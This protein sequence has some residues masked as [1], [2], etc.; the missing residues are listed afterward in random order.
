MLT[1]YEGSVSFDAW[2]LVAGRVLARLPAA[3]DCGGPLDLG[4]GARVPR[5]KGAGVV[6]PR[7]V[8][9]GGPWRGLG[10]VLNGRRGGPRGCPLVS[11]LTLNWL[12]LGRVPVVDPSLLPPIVKGLGPS[13]EVPEVVM[14]GCDPTFWERIPDVLACKFWL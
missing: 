3:A 6:M 13:L 4:S 8:C 12:K 10:A 7:E 2:I 1:V 11:A 5:R 9:S 14:E